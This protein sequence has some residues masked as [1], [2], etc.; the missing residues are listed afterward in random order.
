[1]RCLLLAAGAGRRLRAS[2]SSR[3]TEPKPLVR[4]LGLPLIERA[5]L[6]AKQAGCEEFY[7]VLGC[8]GER[9]RK[10][11]GD[12]RRLGVRLRFLLN[13]QWE[14]GNGTSVLAAR[15]VLQ[16]P[17]LLLM[18]DHLLDPSVLRSLQEAYERGA[19]DDAD[20]VVAVDRRPPEGL[21]LE[22][23]TKVRLEGDRVVEIGKCLPSY[24]AIDM[25]A[26]L[27]SPR[28]FDAL[29]Q[30][31]EDGSLTAG[32]RY[33]AQQNRA[34]ALDVSGTFWF[35]VDTPEALRAAERALLRQLPKP[36]D[37]PVS[38]YLNRPI[39]TRL[40]R[41]LVN[42]PLTPNQLSVLSFLLAAAGA[43]A[44][45]LPSYAALA[46]GGLLAQIS[47]V[48]D[49]CDGEVARLKFQGSE[50]GGWFDAVLDRYADALLVS[51]LS[52]HASLVQ[53][54]TAPWLWGLAALSGVL[55]NSY[56][57]D[58][59]DAFLKKRLAEGKRPL[60]LGRDVRLFL[61][62]LGAILNAPLVTLGLLAVL[63]HGEIVRRVV[64]LARHT[65]D[66]RS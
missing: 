59:Y 65:R 40:T 41:W 31:R 6:A 56:T 26:F 44:M 33:L 25:G 32:V 48:L 62:F 50:F 28:I 63:S 16:E 53:G 10:H 19:L 55:L 45:A 37:G 54:G 21:D 52:V 60:R 18:S 1:M 20:V 27:C 47:S 29:E 36:T 58:K 61:V 3:P 7:V 38:R 64:L 12:G 30:T 34:K 43:L 13:P 2:A 57:A 35:D 14:R 42:T 66:G 11:L 22:D 46:V 24:D 49:G 15:E 39:S 51:G 8:E 23:A 4:L 9:V 5:I 17:F